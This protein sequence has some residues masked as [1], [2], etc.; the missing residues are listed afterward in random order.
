[1][2]SSNFLSELKKRVIYADGAMGTVLQQFGV[3]EGCPE[4][5]NLTNPYLIQ[6]IHKAY[7]DAG[8]NILLTNT[9][10][11]S[12]LKL[13]KYGL[14]HKLEEINRAGVS[15]AKEVL[16][17]EAAYDCLIAA[18]V[19]ELGEYLEPL[20]KLT[21]D[22]ACRLFREQLEP[23]QDADII[24]IETVSDIK[25]LKAA[26]IAAKDFAKPIITSM[27]FENDLRTASGTDV[28]T[29]VKI[30]DALG[31]DVI[32]VNCSQGPEGI[33]KI[34]EIMAKNTNKPLLVKPNA[35]IPKLIDGKTVF[36]ANIDVFAEYA[37]K[38]VAAGVNIIGGCCGTHPG[39]IKAI[40]KVTRSQSPVE[41]CLEPRTYFCSRTRTVELNGSVLIVG[42]RINPSGRKSFREELK[43]GE[44][45]MLRSEAVSQRD[46]GAMLLDINVGVPGT[47]ET[48]N[49]KRAVSIV[50]N[51]VDLPLVI[52]TSN[53]EALEEA[54]KQCDGR[55]LI[56]SINGDDKSLSMILPLAKKYGAG[57]IALCLDKEGI[58]ADVEGRIKIA[59][60]I[61]A[62]AENIG[63]N[64]TD[65]IVDC[66]TMTIAT[67]PKNEDIILQAVKEVRKMGLRTILGV[68]N[69][70]Y[71]LPGRADINQKFFTKAVQNGLDMAIL[72]P[73]DN[74]FRKDTE[75]SVNFEKKIID[76]NELGIRERLASAIIF[77]DNDNIL[78]F[79]KLGLNE[80]TAF[81]VNE[82]MISA[83]EEVGRKFNNKEIFLPQVL[84]SAEAMKTAFSRLKSEFSS[85]GGRAGN[86]S[87][88]IVFA[89]VEN[90]IHDIGKNI[91]IAILEGS[92]FEIIDLGRDV[93]LDRIINTALDNKADMIA[94]SALMTTTAPEME[95][96]INKLN[97]R[98]IDI[99]VIVG[100]A[101]ITSD[102]A[103]D[104]GAAYSHDAL[105]AV[106]VIKEFINSRR[107]DKEEGLLIKKLR[108]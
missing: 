89:T 12:R 64:K 19:S 83:L 25:T 67:D 95:K 32:G 79:V 27:T 48:A 85:T 6:S 107:K 54:L 63:L 58:P 30:A 86:E 102:Y 47:D 24:F 41:R 78:E 33:Y 59:K 14:A 51:L 72:N 50:Q 60:K 71:G 23:L 36:D 104:I 68:S 100:G 49:L 31:A 66:L 76:Y 80:Y 4:E 75:I 45:K 103:M 87:I 29:Y 44:S 82:L 40:V 16:K 42:E 9:F 98:N 84:L 77:G 57:V 20:G 88:R 91:V 81:E 34:A 61:F 1:M 96:I 70:S 108:D 5:L 90:D 13:E 105:S 8:A 11:A 62:A 73:E 55:P 15:L 26:V 97:E 92:G 37:R 22:D 99:P 101:V 46:E 106:K 65:I 7:L 52:D 21:F 69:I 56:N 38:L 35:G 28:Q 43:K 18:D 93:S 10:G 39:Y 2:T 17:K 74:V 94:L 53:A 3:R